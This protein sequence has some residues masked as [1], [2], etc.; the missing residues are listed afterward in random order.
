MKIAIAKTGGCFTARWVAVC[1]EKK[2]DYVLVNPHDSDIVRQLKE[3]THFLWHWLHYDPADQLSARQLLAA[4]KMLGI[5]AYPNIETCWHFDDKLAQ[6][7]LLEST[8]LPLVNT[9][10]FYSFEKANDWSKKAKYP[11]VFKLR[12]G[13]GS[14]NVR[15]VHSPK[16]AKRLLCVMFKKGIPPAPVRFAGAIKAAKTSFL[17]M[18]SS[19]R[20]IPRYI[21]GVISRRKLPLQIGYCLFQ[22]F[23]EGNTYDTRI[24]VIG[25]RAFGI[26]RGVRKN[27]FRASGSGMIDYDVDKIS[28]ECV[29]IAFEA[30]RRLST[31]SLALDFVKDMSGKSF[32]VEV[33]Y[34]FSVEAYYKCAGYW[35]AKLRWHEGQVK[36]EDWILE[37]LIND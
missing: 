37:D 31:Q 7:Y 28:L 3:C 13:A 15:M 17:E 6:K 22:E 10:V 34:G 18:V 35:D 14:N 12:M 32:I 26:T 8:N 21:S 23:I 25:N 27:D 36:P 20:K 11:L 1:K 4:V 16:E 5:K 19:I 9:Y 30:S 29:E 2:L 24:V 33:S